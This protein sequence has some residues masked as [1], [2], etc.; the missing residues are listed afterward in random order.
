VGKVLCAVVLGLERESI[1]ALRLCARMRPKVEVEV[2]H[3]VAP[4]IGDNLELLN[5]MIAVSFFIK[6][7]T[8]RRR[9]CGDKY[10]SVEER[11]L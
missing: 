4:G 7:L 11:T 1:T 5:N 6:W 8:L 2:L 9:Q 10:Q 3:I